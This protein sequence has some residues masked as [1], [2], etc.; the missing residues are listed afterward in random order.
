M[1]RVAD[2]LEISDFAVE[3]SLLG[4]D[5]DGFERGVGHLWDWLDGCMGVD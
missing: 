2:A 1:L 3:E 4:G 5:G